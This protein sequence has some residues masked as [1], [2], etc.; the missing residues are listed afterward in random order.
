MISS[1][2]KES[3][4]WCEHRN[5]QM[6]ISIIILWPYAWWM[7]RNQRINTFLSWQVKDIVL[8]NFCA[9]VN[10]VYCLCS[11]FLS[12]LIFDRLLYRDGKHL[13]LLKSNVQNNHIFQIVNLM[14]MIL[15]DLEWKEKQSD[16][17]R[18]HWKILVF[19]DRFP[20]EMTLRPPLLLYCPKCSVQWAVSPSR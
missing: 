6:T 10:S 2:S 15:F 13:Q 1:H 12:L 14:S 3:V 17:L 18:S 9:F 19:Y 20:M 4:D 7:M 11:F 8:T 16:F 5:H